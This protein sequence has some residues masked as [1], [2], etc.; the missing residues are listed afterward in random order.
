[1]SRA[2]RAGAFGA[3]IGFFVMVCILLFHVH[4]SLIVNVLWPTHF[5]ANTAK[6]SLWMLTVGTL[7]FFANAFLY[8]LTG[9]GIGRLMYG[10][11][12]PK[13]QR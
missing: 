13:Q 9:Y 4:S 10:K 2:M 1:M 6:G 7:G 8:G 3:A 12:T 11:E 5:L